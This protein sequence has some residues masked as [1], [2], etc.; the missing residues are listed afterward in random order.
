MK[1]MAYSSAKSGIINRNLFLFLSFT[2]LT[3]FASFGAD[4]IGNKENISTTNSIVVS[5]F[6]EN[7]A[8]CFE[9]EGTTISANAQGGIP[10]YSYLW[11]T[12]E[13]TSEIFVK[14]GS[15]SV[16]IT[17]KKG[18][19]IGF[20]SV[21]VIQ[22]L[23]PIIAD[24]GEDRIVCLTDLP[25]ILEGSVTGADSGMWSGDWGRFS[26]GNT[27]GEATYKP[28]AFEIANGSATLVL[29]T[30]GTGNCPTASDTVT[31][32]FNHFNADFAVSSTPASYFGGNDGSATV[33]ITG[34]QGPYT[35]VWNSFPTQIGSTATA[36]P[37]GT[38]Q[39]EMINNVGCGSTISVTVTEP[40]VQNTASVNSKNV[41]H[42][43]GSATK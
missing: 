17:D 19:N 10:P 34:E 20:Q 24:A 14:S 26:Y 22:N 28:T 36:L 6:P 7:P 9:A 35:C 21:D 25:I 11:N 41:I 4:E 3:S 12:G 5:I 13:T 39:V 40:P 29:S 27:P 18:Q 33:S 30:I 43:N 16:T 8:V 42:T 37:A 2:I 31:F 32:V 23:N 15:Y 1:T 38:Y